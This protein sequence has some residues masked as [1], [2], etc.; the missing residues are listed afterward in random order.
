MGRGVPRTEETMYTILYL[1]LPGGL[2]ARESYTGTRGKNC[3]L[4]CKRGQY[5]V[6]YSIAEK[7]VF[8]HKNHFTIYEYKDWTHGITP[9]LTLI[10][11]RHFWGKWSP[12]GY[13][14]PYNPQEDLTCT[15]QLIKPHSHPFKK[16]DP[17]FLF[18]EFNF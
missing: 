3:S 16:S 11:W 14:A 6:I 10:G 9:K 8:S 15:F 7:I 13:T 1:N 12:K 18:S 4:C 17:Y 2:L 5:P